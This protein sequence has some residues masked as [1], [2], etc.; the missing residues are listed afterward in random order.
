VVSIDI[1]ADELNEWGK[2]RCD[3]KAT[4]VR[5]KNG[6]ST[7]MM[8][9]ENTQTNKQTRASNTPRRASQAS[10]YILRLILV[11]LR[12]SLAEVGGCVRH[13]RQSV[14]KTRHECQQRGHIFAPFVILFHVDV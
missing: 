10:Q 8:E 12:H 4:S 11:I 6:Y 14:R 7:V 13:Q 3:T 9:K 2:L 1:L 5:E